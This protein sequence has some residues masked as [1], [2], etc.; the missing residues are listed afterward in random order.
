M[1]GIFETIAGPIIGGLFGAFGQEQREDS[2][3]QINTQNAEHQSAINA[4]NV[5]LARETRV[6]NEALAREMAA[7]N[8]AQ[9]REFAQMGLRW[10]VED[11]KA[12][13]LHPVYAIGGS[14]AAFAPHPTITH[15]A[16]QVGATRFEASE[17]PSYL[18]SMGQD[19]GRAISAT[20]DPVQ[21]AERA[22]QLKL[23]EKQVDVADAQ[24]Q[25]YRSRGVMDSSPGGTTYIPAAAGAGTDPIYLIDAP[26]LKD[27]IRAQPSDVESSR[28]SD[29]SSTPGERPMW[30]DYSAFGHTVRLPSKGATEALESLE[31]LGAIATISENVRYHRMLDGAFRFLDAQS[32]GVRRGF[33]GFK[34]GLKWSKEKLPGRRFSP[35]HVRGFGKFN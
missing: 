3:A 8:E 23:L 34:S 27:T 16:P 35:D 6:A 2:Q 32:R 20:L 24:A 25:Y 18:A 17:G 31:P 9:Q 30:S 28:T 15:Q 33:E 21:A 12:A 26:Y 22:L 13:G 5:A 29:P 14:G 10:K 7:R 19:I 11:A 4:E 1:A